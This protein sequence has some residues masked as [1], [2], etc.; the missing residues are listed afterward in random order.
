MTNITVLF[1][2]DLDYLE[3]HQTEALLQILKDKYGTEEGFIKTRDQSFDYIC[4]CP[5]HEDKK[6][7]NGR[8]AFSK[9]GTLRLYCNGACSSE[10]TSTWFFDRLLERLGVDHY[11]LGK[12]VKLFP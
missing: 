9:D 1:D 4:R 5:V 11:L 8:V 12:K 10:E 7:P 3:D 2:S 6:N